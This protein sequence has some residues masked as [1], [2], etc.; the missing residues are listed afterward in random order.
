MSE[1][2]KRAV[3]L[4]KD[5]EDACIRHNLNLTVYDGKIGFVDQAERKIVCLWNPEYTLS[6]S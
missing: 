4:K 5:I 1:A 3:E 2:Q 6:E